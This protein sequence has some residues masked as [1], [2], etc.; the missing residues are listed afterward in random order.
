MDRSRFT[1][2]CYR[3]ANWQA[4]GYTRGFAGKPGTPVTWVAHGRPKRCWST[5]RHA[6]RASSF[7][8]STIPQ[9]AKR[10][11]P[12]TVERSTTAKP[13][14][15]PAW[16]AGLPKHARSALSAGDHR[17]HRGRRKACRIPR[18]DCDWGV[19]PRADSVSA[20]RSSR[21][22][23]P[24]SWALSV[25]PTQPV[26]SKSGDRLCTEQKF[27]PGGSYGECVFM[28]GRVRT[29]FSVTYSD[30]A[31]NDRGC[32]RFDEVPFD[33]IPG[34]ASGAS[35]QVDET[36]VAGS[37]WTPGRRPG[38]HR[39]RAGN[40]AHE[41][42]A[43][44]AHPPLGGIRPDHRVPTRPGGQGRSLQGRSR[45]LHVRRDHRRRRGVRSG[46]A[47]HLSRSSPGFWGRIAAK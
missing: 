22:L 19:L 26:P 16:C 17:G 36:C 18:R 27:C 5:R 23:Q 24:A 14:G 7:A 41:G 13:V 12:A 47:L 28:S 40:P 2:A 43:L 34:E 42:L 11:R 20:S 4:L 33:R 31:R 30:Y 25:A 6:T 21:I 45:R 1:S 46:G 3:A 37:R 35:P 8:A 38:A 32:V 39:P 44:L 29:G 9:L 10:R 15:V